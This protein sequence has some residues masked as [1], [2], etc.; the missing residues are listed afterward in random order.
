MYIENANMG[1]VM[2]VLRVY[3]VTINLSGERIPIIIKT[4]QTGGVILLQ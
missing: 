2:S 1:V 3:S 4:S